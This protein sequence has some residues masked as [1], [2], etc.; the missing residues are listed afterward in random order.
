MASSLE[1]DNPAGIADS[2]DDLPSESQNTNIDFFVA[3]FQLVALGRA[4]LTRL[5]AAT[6]SQL[7]PL[8]EIER[9]VR[10]QCEAIEA[11]CAPTRR[12]PRSVVRDDDDADVDASDVDADPEAGRRPHNRWAA[13]PPRPP[14]P[15]D[16]TVTT[17]A[18]TGASDSDGDDGD[19]GDDEGDRGGGGGAGGFRDGDALLEARFRS[20]NAVIALDDDGD[21][22][23]AGGGG[24]GGL[25][26]DPALAPSDGYFLVV[27]KTPDPYVTRHLYRSST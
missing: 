24:G 27:F 22:A 23:A 1:H 17:I 13:P 7:A 15:P 10:T 3:R 20:P 21:A 6:S 5:P 16:G 19:D 18:G 9:A 12:A 25:L 26:V 14:R 11:R 2:S 8:R 4:F